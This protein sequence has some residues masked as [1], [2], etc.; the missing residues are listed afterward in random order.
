MAVDHRILKRKREGKESEVY[1]DGNLMRQKKVR[2]ETLRNKLPP[3]STRHIPSGAP[4]PELPCGLAV[5]TP[6]G[7][8]VTWP[9]TPNLPWLRF[10][11]FLERTG[12]FNL[13]SISV[14][15]S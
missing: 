3:A 2:K 14:P 1:R 6:A 5:C 8:E 11:S 13:K 10:A 4:S 15:K 9:K 7:S 12:I